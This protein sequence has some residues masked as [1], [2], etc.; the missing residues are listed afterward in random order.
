M[1]VEYL[2]YA[3]IAL[4][5]IKGLEFVEEAVTAL[6]YSTELATHLFRECWVEGTGRKV[7]LCRAFGWEVEAHKFKVATAAGLVAIWHNARITVDR[8]GRP[9]STSVPPVRSRQTAEAHRCG[10]SAQLA[11]SVPPTATPLP[12]RRAA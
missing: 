11:A 5:P 8:P 10:A 1:A 2:G 9:P 6:G 3:V 4:H 7:D 12:C